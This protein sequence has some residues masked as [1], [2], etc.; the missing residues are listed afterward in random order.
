MNSRLYSIVAALLLLAPGLFAANKAKGKARQEPLPTP[1]HADVKY[2]PHE[3]NV[4]D[5]WLAKSDKP[6]P[7]VVF[8]HGGGFV[9]GDKSKAKAESIKRCLDDG[10]SFMSI[11]YRFRDHASIQDILRDAAR[12]IQFIR[13]HAA[14]YNIDPKRIA[15]HGGSAGAGTSLWLAVHDDLADPNNADLVLRQ[16][17]RIV[18]AGCINGQATYNMTEWEQVIGKFKAEW[19]RS[20]GEDVQFY[21]F[22]SRDDYQ[23]PEGKKILADCSMLR[24]ITKDDPPIFMNCNMPDTEP[25][26][27][28]QLVHHPRHAKAVK[29]RCDELGVKCEIHLNDPGD[30]I[31]FLLQQ[32]G[33]QSKPAKPAAQ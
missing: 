30:V 32:L 10:V 6:A 9:A 25:E 13:L 28:G 20:E 12:A 16:S 3:R 33:I 4:L 22:K 2:G 31:G 14:E 8:I 19:I 21:H 11:N 23:T 27:R 24:Q 1:T 17:S 29:Q 5:L 15:S 7:L 26:N 18:A